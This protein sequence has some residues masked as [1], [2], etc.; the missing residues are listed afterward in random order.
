MAGTFKLGAYL[1]W[2]NGTVFQDRLSGFKSV[3]GETPSLISVTVDYTQ[4]MSAWVANS[5]SS[6][7]LVKNA[8]GTSVTPVLSLGLASTVADG[9]SVQQR[10]AKVASGAYDSIYTGIINNYK[11]QGFST[12]DVRIGW[13]MNGNWYPWGVSNAVEAQG[14]VAAFRHVA[15]L[16]HSIS[17][18]QVDTVWNPLS[19]SWFRYNTESTYPGDHYV[20]I[21]GA[22]I[23]SGAY[24]LTLYDWSTGKYD[25]SFQQWYSNPANLLHYWDYPD[26]D[27]AHPTG[28]GSGWGL[29]EAMNFAKLHNKP[30]ALPETGAGDPAGT[31]PTDNA[32]FP[33][34]L[35]DRL[36]SAGAPQ[37]AFVSLFNGGNYVFTDGS[38]PNVASA[39]TVFAQ[40]MLGG[41]GAIVTATV[42]SY[43]TLSKG[44]GN[45]AVTGA[46]ASITRGTVTLG[47]GTSSVTMTGWADVVTIGNGNETVSLTGSNMTVTLGNGAETVSLTGSY[48]SVT[49]GNTP[50]GSTSTIQLSGSTNTVKAGTG[51]VVVNGAATTGGT[52]ITL[53]NG[54]DTVT[55]SGSNN[56]VTVGTGASTITVGNSTAYGSKITTGGALATGGTVNVTIVGKSNTVDL[57]AG[58]NVVTS[59]AGGTGDRFIVNGSGQGLTTISGFAIGGDSLDLTRTLASTGIGTDLTKIATYVKAS[60]ANGGADTLLSVDPTGSGAAGYG[61]VLLKGVVASNTM[62]S[63]MLAKNDFVLR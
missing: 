51:A 23:Y 6:A 28:K 2:P 22:N 16:V 11:N 57:G 47:D 35:A 39:W 5:N 4:P 3:V 61:F 8:L 52:T 38:K 55:L 32:L 20:D 43:G 50:A 36:T 14:Y 7:T 10:L 62:I 24:P 26:A 37:I 29:V 21:I 59:T 63:D 17:G 30:F 60:A 1:G 46:T 15:D 40:R 33:K 45:Y 42:A 58:T 27:A 41:T 12:L 54:A 9:L 18:I 25:S 44:A 48:G 56:V 34:Y 13:E 53:G 49:I 31:G 19:S